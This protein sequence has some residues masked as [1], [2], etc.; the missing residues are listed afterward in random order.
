VLM[1]GWKQAPISAVA[2]RFLF[3]DKYFH[4]LCNTMD[5]MIEC[6]C[7][8]LSFTVFEQLLE[9]LILFCKLLYLHGLLF[10]S[11]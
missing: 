6:L 9:M 4:T 3:S 7:L 11:A 1:V 2:S 10:T 8:W 5:V